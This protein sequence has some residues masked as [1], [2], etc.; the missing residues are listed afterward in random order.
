M[1]SEYDYHADYDRIS[2]TMISLFLKS[3]M[4]FHLTY[5]AKVMPPKAPKKRMIVGLLG[6]A[7]LME[8][9]KL[10]QLA[11][12][13]PA[14]CLNKNGDINPTPAEK[15]RN[16][17]EGYF[18]LKPSDYRYVEQALA[19]M[20][21]YRDF[22]AVVEQ[23]TSL[24]EPYFADSFGL[25][26]KCKPDI[27]C[28]IGDEIYIYDPKFMENIDPSSFWMSAKRF[29]YWLQQT[30]YTAVVKAHFDKPVKFRFVAIETKFPFRQ[31]WY[32]YE[33]TDLDNAQ[34][35]YKKTMESLKSRYDSGNWEDDWE[36]ALRLT[37]WDVALT[38]DNALTPFDF[39]ADS[40]ETNISF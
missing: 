2:K 5:I 9:K 32:W 34:E 13:Y 20:A 8:K 24:E 33:E 29:S 38:D 19:A 3:P 10:N 4:E 36:S 40:A 14:S 21:K 23:A 37:P 7:V 22:M 31:K 28:D 26:C 1:T 27:L 6:H 25:P 17:C 16:E 11:V 18:C 30:H 12:M 39:D 15:F 35:A